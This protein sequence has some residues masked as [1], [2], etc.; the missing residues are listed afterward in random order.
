VKAVP[1]LFSCHDRSC[2]GGFGFSAS[3]GNPQPD[4]RFDKACVG[5]MVF[6]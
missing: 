4:I 6:R 3:F 5:S 2:S 1:F